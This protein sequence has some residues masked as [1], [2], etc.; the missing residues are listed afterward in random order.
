MI[1]IKMETIRFFP[2]YIVWHY[3]KAF[4]NVWGIWANFLWFVY[5]FFSLPI[6]ARTFFDPWQRM[7]EEYKKGFDP[8]EFFSTLV[9]NTLMRI[10]GVFMRFFVMVIGL[11]SLGAVFFLGIVSFVVWAALPVLILFFLAKGAL[12]FI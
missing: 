5:H 10:V 11:V 8:K 9:V 2:N 4:H 12:S 7:G 1:A 6:L 3:T